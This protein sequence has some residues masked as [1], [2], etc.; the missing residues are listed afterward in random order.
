MGAIV[1][2]PYAYSLMRA[3]AA[4]QNA[5]P[6][7]VRQMSFTRALAAVALFALVVAGYGASSTTHAKV[8][9]KDWARELDRGTSERRGNAVV[10]RRARWG[11]TER[12]TDSRVSGTYRNAFDIW[13]Y[14]D[15]RMHFADVTF[16]LKNA[17]GA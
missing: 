13:G 4:R 10:M 3:E 9:G 2:R 1:R 8:V 12:T 15:S 6:E 5:P 16:V 17:R 14:P 11:G 7:E